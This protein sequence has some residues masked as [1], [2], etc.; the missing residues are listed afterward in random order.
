M[1]LYNIE[2]IDINISLPEKWKWWEKTDE[3]HSDD[4]PAA[5][6][7]DSG[8]E[9]ETWSFLYLAAPPELTWL[10]FFPF[11]VFHAPLSNY[12]PM[13]HPPSGHNDH[14]LFFHF[15]KAVVH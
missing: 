4:P 14:I 1:T 15:A 5:W 2:G 10:P 6:N 11:R 9:K 12:H 7:F 13:L 3:K 8:G